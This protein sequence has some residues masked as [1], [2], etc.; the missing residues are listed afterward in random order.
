MDIIFGRAY[1]KKK[2]VP[3]VDQT[4]T[5]SH[6]NFLVQNRRENKSPMKEH[7][8]FTTRLDD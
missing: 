8:V 7:E 4:E 2:S 5:C 3:S 6:N 1:L